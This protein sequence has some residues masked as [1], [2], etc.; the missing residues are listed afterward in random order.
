M[1]P[2]TV[3]DRGNEKTLIAVGSGFVVERGLTSDR[4]RRLAEVDLQGMAERDV[5]IFLFGEAVDASLHFD[6]EFFGLFLGVPALDDVDLGLGGFLHVLFMDLLDDIYK[7]FM[8]LGQEAILIDG[9]RGPKDPFFLVVR[10]E[11]FEDHIPHRRVLVHGIH[12]FWFHKV[13]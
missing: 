3:K 11:V 7:V 12:G 4:L 6:L 1:G 2:R 9:L 8:D 5:K 10:R 13:L